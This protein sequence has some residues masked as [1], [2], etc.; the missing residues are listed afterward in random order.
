MK[1]RKA[2]PAKSVKT[3]GKSPVVARTG[4]DLAR[5]LELSAED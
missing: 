4:R 2:V 1:S 5:L 3:S